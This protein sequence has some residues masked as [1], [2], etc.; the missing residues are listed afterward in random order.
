[1]L[2][3]LKMSCVSYSIY[4]D[5]LVIDNK[6]NCGYNDT[7]GDDVENNKSGTPLSRPLHYDLSVKLEWTSIPR[8]RKCLG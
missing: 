2:I 1:M 6:N 4:L 3:M 8:A 7:N 5:Y